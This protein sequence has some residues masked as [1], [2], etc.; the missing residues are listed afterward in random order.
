VLRDLRA[1]CATLALVGL[2][3]CAPLV[4]TGGG[5]APRAA[6]ETIR[7]QSVKGRATVQR[8]TREIEL[9]PGMELIEGEPLQVRSRS[10]LR[11]GVD[12]RALL[13]LGPQS[14]LVIHKRSSSGSAEDRATWLRLERGYLR[15]VWNDRDDR[16]GRGGRWPVEV[17]FARW[18]ARGDGGEYFFDADIKSAAVCAARGPLRLSGVPESAPPVIDYRCARLRAQQ[19]PQ[20]TVLD[21]AHWDAMRETSTLKPVLAKAEAT[22]AAE[23]KKALAA[24]EREMAAEVRAQAALRAAESKRLALA[25]LPQTPKSIALSPLLPAVAPSIE[26]PLARVPQAADGL[27]VQTPDMLVPLAEPPPAPVV[28][29][30]SE[31]ASAPDLSA[32]PVDEPVA[33]APRNDAAPNEP[34]TVDTAL[35]AAQGEPVLP[36]AGTATEESNTTVAL[37]T[38]P[39]QGPV[40]EAP[41][42]SRTESVDPPASDAR[43]IVNVATHAARRDA[44]AQADAL[45][46][47]GFPASVLDEQIQG[48]PSYRVVV[49]DRYDEPSAMQIV[50]QLDVRLGVQTAWILR[51]R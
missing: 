7:V 35:Q 39:A 1:A 23:A 47:N 18:L 13:E 29:A 26:S 45:R 36:P 44:Q 32:S 10:L 37:A 22:E 49:A 28:V 43:W 12:R 6:P 31:P 48:L 24:L 9:K 25:R 5:D 42:L 41:M 17:S 27:A 38:P 34:V 50:E 21:A 14:R 16:V 11:L 30:L 15:V 19:R 40:D 3:S 51:E 33:E 46:A 4:P 2:A 8:G 20:L